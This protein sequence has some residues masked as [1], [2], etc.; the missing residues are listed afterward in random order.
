MTEIA[1]RVAVAKQLAANI[2]E[3]LGKLTPKQM[4]LPSACDQWQ[5][6][7]VVSH[8]VGGAERQAGSMERGRAGNH[9]P[10]DGFVSV[11]NQTMSNSNAQRDIE[12]RSKLAGGLL[13]AYDENYAWL[14]DEYDKYAAGSWDTLAWHARRGAMPGSDYLLLRIQ[15]LAIHDWDIR[16]ALDPNA[17][18]DPASIPALLDMS[19][20]WLRMCFRPSEKL[21][22]PVVYGFGLGPDQPREYRLEVTGDAF[23]MTSG[24]PSGPDLSVSA[25]A[26]QYLLFTYGRLS[27]AHGISS[28]KLSAEGDPSHLDRFEACFKGL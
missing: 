22:R 2:R 5:V 24:M 23:E 16:S 19:P 15:E 7:D 12:R 14:H 21:A 25:T 10:P 8:L 20:N 11:D 9:E 13:Q 6:Q 18:L 17:G 1:D 26:Q 4:E 28:G 27:A 3:Y